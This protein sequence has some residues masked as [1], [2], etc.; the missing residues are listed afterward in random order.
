MG[1]SVVASMH[2]ERKAAG[3]I[4]KAAGVRSLV[5]NFRRSLEDKYPSQVEDAEAAFGWLLAQGYRAENIGRVGHSVG[6]YL[7][8]MLALTPRDKGTPIPGAIVSISPWCDLEISDDA[9]TTNA[10][11]DTLLSEPPLKFFRECWL[12]GTGVAFDDPGV[13]LLNADLRGLPP[14]SV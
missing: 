2:S 5:V 3:H 13:S 11:A 6:G 9:M 14:T 4:A 7:A 8:V 1:G 12:G 10:D